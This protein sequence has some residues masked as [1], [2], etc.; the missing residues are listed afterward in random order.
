M[1]KDGA[2]KIGWITFIKIIY[3]EIDMTN[4][5]KRMLSIAL[6]LLHQSKTEQYS[7]YSEKD[8]DLAIRI[9]NEL[10]SCEDGGCEVDKV[11]N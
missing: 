6:D 11:I 4:I 10:R 2:W 3:R 7:T 1:S 5:E 8:I 9:I